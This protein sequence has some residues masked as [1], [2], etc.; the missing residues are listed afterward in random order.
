MLLVT[1]Q[2]NFVC[3]L[4]VRASGVVVPLPIFFGVTF[5]KIQGLQ[6]F[7]PIKTNLNLLLYQLPPP[8]KSQYTKVITFEI[9]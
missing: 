1:F 5:Q 6:I 4:C 7:H 8:V 9:N 3:D 2:Q